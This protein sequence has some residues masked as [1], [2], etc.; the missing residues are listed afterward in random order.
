MRFILKLV[1]FVFLFQNHT[2]FCQNHEILYRILND[3]I[4]IDPRSPIIELEFELINK[5]DKDY[6]LYSYSEIDSY[7]VDFAYIKNIQR[8]NCV[9][10]NALYILQGYKIRIGGEPFHSDTGPFHRFEEE[11]LHSDTDSFAIFE[12]ESLDNEITDPFKAT[13]ILLRRGT[14]VKLKRQINLEYFELEP[15]EYKLSLV[16]Y[17]GKNISTYFTEEE[18]SAEE[19]EYGATFFRGWVQSNSVPL[20][21]RYER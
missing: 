4:I 9:V 13:S 5:S 17:S 19:K 10:G 20:I 8:L 21:V 2:A 11:P 15:W 18:I 6:M 7:S 16:Y 12:E 1:V 3:T 14:T